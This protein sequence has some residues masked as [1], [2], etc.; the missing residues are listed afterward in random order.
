[1]K[2]FGN[3]Y[4]NVCSIEN[5]KEAHR[6]ARKDKAYYKEVKMV[7][8]N[9]DYY[10]G[11]IREML[12]NKK[13]K[14]SEYTVSIIND[15]GKERELRK[16]PYFPDRIIQWAIMLQ[17]E[18]ILLN[19]MCSH[20]CASIPGRGIKRGRR[21]M[22]RYLSDRKETVYAL[23]IDI[24]H[25][26]PSIDHEILKKMLRTKFKDPDLLWL[27]DLIIDSIPGGVGIPI[28]SYLSQYLANFYLSEFDHLMKEKLRVKRV[29]RYMDDV[30]VLAGTKKELREILKW[31]QEYLPTIKLQLKDNYQIFP[32]ESRGIDFLGFRFFHDFVLLR[33]KTKLKMIARFEHI[34]YKW[35]HGLILNRTEYGSMCSYS[36]WM[37]LFNSHRLRKKYY[38]PIELAGIVYYTEKILKPKMKRKQ[39]K[40]EVKAA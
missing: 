10:L 33:K 1:M 40:K 38:E 13:Y 39:L 32:V 21:L 34:K 11:K 31:M 3:I 29:V 36:G 15:T 6:N 8:S 17:I 35:D 23:K 24:H 27:L 2:R 14:V 25:F 30:T 22:K 28:G 5:I 37:R 12:V 9:P 4:E 16:L 19:T 26:Y 18:H 7:D 20:T